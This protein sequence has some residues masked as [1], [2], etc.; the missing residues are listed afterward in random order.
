MFSERGWGHARSKLLH[1][2][3]RPYPRDLRR[4]WRTSS[5]LARSIPDA[6]AADDIG[7]AFAASIERAQDA[8][9]SSGTAFTGFDRCLEIN[10]WIIAE[11]ARAVTGSV[12]GAGTTNYRP[13][14]R[15][16]LDAGQDVGRSGPAER[17]CRGCQTQSAR[18]GQ[19]SGRFV[20]GR[21]A[22]TRRTCQSRF[23]AHKPNARLF[24]L[25]RFT[26]KDDAVEA[27]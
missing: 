16:A 4:G 3:R 1:L 22:A 14:P 21:A 26:G 13:D 6:T 20:G 23:P 15:S 17:A 11:N 10:R 2:Q 7:V 24:E 27:S 9:A 5:N 18:R 8:A 12:A 19:N 25:Q